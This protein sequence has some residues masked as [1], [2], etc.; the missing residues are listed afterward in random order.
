MERRGSPSPTR[1]GASCL[2]KKRRKRRR[3]AEVR[4]HALAAS[5]FDLEDFFDGLEFLSPRELWRA[6]LAGDEILDNLLRH[7][8]PLYSDIILVRAARRDS[9][10]V[11]GFFFRSKAFANFASQCGDL[12]PLVAPLFDPENRRWRGIGL[13][14]CRN[15]C[16]DIYMRPG[17]ELDRIFLR[18]APD[19]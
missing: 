4:L 16:Q 11:L 5:V 3:E 18:I 7:A 12:D 15:L 14:M 2:H 19:L 6:K 17:S 8:L 1:G 9:G 13:V 10:I